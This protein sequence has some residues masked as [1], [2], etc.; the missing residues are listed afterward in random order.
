MAGAML[1]KTGSSPNLTPDAINWV[2]I[3]RG[4]GVPAVSVDRAED[5][6]REFRTALAEPGPHL[7]EM[8]LHPEG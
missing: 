4:L 7:I 1:K 2:N 5:L 3:S 8:V 6:A